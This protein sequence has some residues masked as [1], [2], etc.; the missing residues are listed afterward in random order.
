MYVSILNDFG[1]KNI[2]Q[3]TL[4]KIK[5]PFSFGQV[6]TQEYIQTLLEIAKEESSYS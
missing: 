1:S 5:I 3:N 2:P 4:L 6:A